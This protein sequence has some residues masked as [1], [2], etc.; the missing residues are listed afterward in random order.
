MQ[1]QPERCQIDP[2]YML[3]KLCHRWLNRLV[4]WMRRLENVA[5]IQDGVFICQSV[6]LKHCEEQGCRFCATVNASIRSE[7]AIEQAEHGSPRQ[8]SLHLLPD[9]PGWSIEI[10]FKLAS[11][12]LRAD[13]RLILCET[14][15][16]EPTLG[17]Q[18]ELLSLEGFAGRP[19]GISYQH[20]HHEHHDQF[21]EKCAAQIKYWLSKC[22]SHGSR[23]EDRRND[24]DD[25]FRLLF[26]GDTRPRLVD[27]KANSTKLTYVTLSHRWEAAT[28][29]SSTTHA[30][31]ADRYVSMPLEEMPPHFSRLAV[32][33]KEVGF[34]FIWI[35]SLCIIQDSKEDWK[36]QSRLMHGIYSNG[37][38]NFAPLECFSKALAKD[39]RNDS[40]EVLGCTLPLSFPTGASRTMVCWNPKN[41][42]RVLQGSTLYSRAWTFQERVLSPRTVHFGRQMYWECC[43]LRACTTF[44]LGVDLYEEFRDDMFLR[45]KQLSS[46]F[47][48][49][50]AQ[51]L[52]RIWCSVLRDYSGRRLTNPG[53]RLIALRG[54][55]ERLWRILGL[56]ENDY[57]FGLWKPCLP[58][59]LLWGME[60]VREIG[61]EHR[62]TLPSWS[63][64]SHA[65]RSHKFVCLFLARISCLRKQW[66]TVT[67][68][69]SASTPGLG[70]V[71]FEDLNTRNT[72]LALQGFPIAIENKCA[73]K[74]ALEFDDGS[75]T[76]PRGVALLPVLQ[77][78][79]IIHGLILEP[80][81]EDFVNTNGKGFH[82]RGIFCADETTIKGLLADPT[83]C[84][85]G[86]TDVHI[87]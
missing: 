70:V 36:Q 7:A 5:H 72:V 20:I 16:C 49:D 22:G 84:P 2:K 78:L 27:V 6:L 62:N 15:S 14:T 37:A 40:M 1:R 66:V 13:L 4:S 53:D 48:G 19:T 65:G 50:F 25:K 87:F 21:S 81:G 57:L 43:S 3:C 39:N 28:E 17:D 34:D 64:A 73:A 74:V 32:L 23:C 71:D 52:H 42:D 30:N 41:F 11:K 46:K 45:L 63:W 69:H 54:V 58:E 38:I 80:V 85:P 9:V 75:S 68:V 31:L 29:A 86:P 77:D 56:S 61:F 82:R 79:Q 12:D 51:D 47:D 55:A 44:P 18:V 33:A 26:L 8:Y 24:V 67:G 59:Q 35:D 83:Y 60:D 10:L 76:P